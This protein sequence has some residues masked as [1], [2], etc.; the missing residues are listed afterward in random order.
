M[1]VIPVYSE[2]ELL[3]VVVT[4]IRDFRIKL[5]PNFVPNTESWV[6]GASERIPHSCTL[7]VV[8]KSVVVARGP[9]TA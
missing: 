1:N 7:A 5:M 6:L 2:S 3:L 4:E 9:P 8:N